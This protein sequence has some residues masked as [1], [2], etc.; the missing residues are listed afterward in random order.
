MPKKKEILD[1][2]REIA[3]S[4][5]KIE[6]KDPFKVPDGYFDNMRSDIQDAI[7]S[8]EKV[9]YLEL[10]KQLILQPRFSIAMAVLLAVVIGGSFLFDGGDNGSGNVYVD[11]EDTTFDE[12]A[13]YIDFNLDDF[14]ETL[15][16]EGSVA[17]NGPD[18]S[19]GELEE[20]EDFLLDE[21]DQQTL[22][23]ELL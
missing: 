17:L 16:Y 3:P 14:D 10:F 12:I 2:L 7:S 8:R 1:E 15:L 19:N 20:I 9:S 22:Q 23:D 18:E 11:I 5:S 6:S 13:A 21:I 4:L